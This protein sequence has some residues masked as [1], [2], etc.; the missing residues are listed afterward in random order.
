MLT[1]LRI[2]S[3][4]F[5]LTA[6]FAAPAFAQ[7]SAAAPNESPWAMRQPS[8]GAAASLTAQQMAAAREA[9]KGTPA[10]QELARKISDAMLNKDYAGIKELIAPS[11][12]KCIGDHQEFLQDRIK[13]QL[14]LPMSH[15]FTLNV[16]QLPANIMK[17]T[18]YSTY[19]MPPTHILG[20]Q[21]VT[22]D[23][24]DATVNL[25]IG[26]EDG[27]WYEVQPCPTQLGLDRFAKMQ[28]AHQEHLDHAKL[29]IAKIKDPVKTQLL[30]LIGQHNDVA[31]WNLCM[32][33]L[34][35]DFPT[36]HG[37]V[38]LLAGQEVD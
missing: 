30:T 10:Q 13:R 3:V 36:C 7:Q 29:A 32:K 17:A 23:N 19:P 4:L 2:V 35:Y 14:E 33:S 15:K 37:V 18:K 8:P 16:S 9:E 31:A 1:S 6:A 21:F 24:R 26:Q 20:I 34:H 25:P 27:K 22:D 38:S 11:T 12:L 5:V 28:H